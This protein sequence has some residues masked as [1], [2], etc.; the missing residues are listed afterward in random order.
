MDKIRVEVFVPALGK[1]Y[2]VEIP[3]KMRFHRIADL[4]ERAICEVSGGIYA[5]CGNA[6]ICD[7][8]TGSPFDINL[9]PD[10]QCLYNGA[11]IIII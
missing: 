5:P 10:K 4:I 2:D 9:W 3:A 1:S 6:L 11:K 7:Y 8:E